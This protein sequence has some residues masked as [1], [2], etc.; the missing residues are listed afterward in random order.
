M[1]V[2]QA[3]GGE[4]EQVSD[5]IF[6]LPATHSALLPK[7]REYRLVVAASPGR[8]PVNS[9]QQFRAAHNA[10]CANEAALVR[11]GPLPRGPIRG[12]GILH[13]LRGLRDDNADRKRGE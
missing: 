6:L 12:S 2:F 4:S 1:S 7:V 11:T 8:T 5:L 3:G 13:E 9:L 10:C